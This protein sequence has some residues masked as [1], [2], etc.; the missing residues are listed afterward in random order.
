MRKL[1][2]RSLICSLQAGDPEKLVIQD[3]RTMGAGGVNTSLRAG[4]GIQVLRYSGTQAGSKR[5]K[6]LLLPSFCSVQGPH[7]IGWFPPMLGRV[8]YFFIPPIQMLIPEI[9]LQA[10]LVIT[11]NLGTLWCSQIDTKLSHQAYKGMRSFMSG[12]LSL[13]SLTIMTFFLNIITGSRHN[14]IILSEKNLIL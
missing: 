4:E 14:E 7:G 11:F 13:I 3:L 6:F 5:G 10:H 12:I 9:L 8:T 1:A 2:Q